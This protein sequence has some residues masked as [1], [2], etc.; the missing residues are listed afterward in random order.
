LVRDLAKVY[1]VNPHQTEAFEFATGMPKFPPGR[2]HQIA[3][4]NRR[5][6]RNGLFSCGDYL[7]GPLVEGAITTG[8]RAANAIPN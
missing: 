1:S 6:R 7:L 4:F 8:F 3:Q 2:Y 5:Q